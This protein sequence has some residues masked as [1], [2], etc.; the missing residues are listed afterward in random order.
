MSKHYANVERDR[1]KKPLDTIMALLHAAA[2]HRGN[3][4]YYSR[5]TAQN[6]SKEPVQIMPKNYAKRFGKRSKGLRKRG[7]VWYLSF[8]PARGERQRHVC[9][10]TTDE[11]EAIKF[12][13]AIRARPQIVEIGTPEEDLQ[14]YI[15]L[16]QERRSM[17]PETIR[18]T[19]EVV[20]QFF[21]FCG[22]TR[23]RDVDEED[24]SKWFQHLKTPKDPKE[25]SVPG[26]TQATFSTYHARLT[27]F[28]RFLVAAGKA[29]SNPLLDFTPHKIPP[30]QIARDAW[31]DKKEIKRLLKKCADRDLKFVLFMGFH[32]GLRK[33]EIVMARPH[34][35]DLKQEKL[36]IPFVEVTIKEPGDGTIEEHHF[37]TKNKRDRSIPLSRAFVE[38]L[39]KEYPWREGQVWCV[40][41]KGK[42]FGQRYRWDFRKPLEAFFKKHG[43]V[44]NT[45]SLRHSFA[46]NCIMAGIS[47]FKVASWLGNRERTV[48]VHY[49]HLATGKGALD[50]VF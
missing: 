3:F 39:R 35:F 47:T 27:A 25:P 44:L 1:W 5:G 32:C 12:A 16:R 13:E 19:E 6:P 30:S 40:E 46:S 22:K 31:I 36:N 17:T 23:S 20:G 8:T 34:W 2:M 21:R 11:I 26:I 43:V 41:R 28:W 37:M 50:R 4:L 29:D 42:G 24:F 9:L 33:K 38:F 14:A 45:H 48:E 18:S 10:N 49:A 15:S 7:N